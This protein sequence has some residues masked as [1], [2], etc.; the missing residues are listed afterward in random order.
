M[1]PLTSASQSPAKALDA[2]T[3][4]LLVTGRNGGLWNGENSGLWFFWLY[5]LG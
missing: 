1:N 3:L 4:G 2:S 5:S